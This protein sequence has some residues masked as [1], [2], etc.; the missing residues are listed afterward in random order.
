MLIFM[1]YATVAVSILSTD[2][3]ALTA[4]SDSSMDSLGEVLLV[5]WMTALI[6]L[7]IAAFGTRRHRPHSMITT[8][9]LA[10]AARS[11]CSPADSAR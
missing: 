6:S 8:L 1:T 2:R 4:Q 7:A 10:V 9:R 3:G 5:V 11:R